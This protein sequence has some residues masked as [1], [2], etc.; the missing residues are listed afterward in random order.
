MAKCVCDGQ[1]IIQNS[2]RLNLFS[3]IYIEISIW[4]VAQSSETRGS[5]RTECLGSQISVKSGE[6]CFFV[7]CMISFL[8]SDLN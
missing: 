8:F 7:I 1:K 5:W 3:N 4:D 2:P 6:K